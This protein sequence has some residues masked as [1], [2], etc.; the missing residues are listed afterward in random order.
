MFLVEMSSL[1][2]PSILFIYVDSPGFSAFAE[3]GSQW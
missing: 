1:S 3:V 2:I